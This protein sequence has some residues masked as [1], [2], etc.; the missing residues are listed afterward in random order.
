[1]HTVKIYTETNTVYK[2]F[3]NRIGS[4]AAREERHK[5]LFLNEVKCLQALRKQFINKPKINHFPFP[6]I[7]SIYEEKYLIKMSYCGATVSSTNI[8]PINVYN[9]IECIINNLKNIPMIYTQ[10]GEQHVCI[11]EIG[12][13]HLIDFDECII[14]KSIK[15]TKW[16]RLNKIYKKPTNVTDIGVHKKLPWSMLNILEK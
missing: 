2:Q 6:K 15:L 12:N 14:D 16:S 1:M 10:M 7:L 13:I 4:K 5:K 9:T 8:K 3:T 11:N